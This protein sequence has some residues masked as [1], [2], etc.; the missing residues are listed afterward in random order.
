MS[1]EPLFADSKGREIAAPLFGGPIADT[2][3]HLDMLDDPALALARAGRAGVG[4][5]ATV[6]DVTEDAWRTYDELP[7]WRSNAVEL[8][9]QMAS[10]ASRSPASE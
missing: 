9:G 7:S 5:V 6:A 2:H 10:Q 1:P 4:L 8:L 3:A